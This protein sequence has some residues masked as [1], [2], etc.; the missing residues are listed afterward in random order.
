MPSRSEPKKLP[1]MI[2]TVTLPVEGMTC[3]SCV[4][5]V[6]KALKR[7]EGVSAAAV[8][9]ATEKATVEFDPAKVTLERLQ[10]AVADSGYTLKAPPAADRGVQIPPESGE[11]TGTAQQ[12]RHDLIASIALTLPV[13]VLSML[14]MT[15]WFQTSFFLTL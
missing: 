14:T 12:L 6:E 10:K 3:A 4:A 11:R 5:R 8:N 15:N 13:M 7:V 1:G 2:E 9:L